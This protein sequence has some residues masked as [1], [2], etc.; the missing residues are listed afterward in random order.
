MLSKE[1]LY[2]VVIAVREGGDSVLVQ[3]ADELGQVADFKQKCRFPPFNLISIIARGY[4]NDP[5]SDAAARK[6]LLK[7][8]LKLPERA[9]KSPET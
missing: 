3:T 5:P 7:R 8:A 6:K 4:W 1:S 2:P 9:S